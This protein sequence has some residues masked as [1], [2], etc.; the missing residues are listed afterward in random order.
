MPPYQKIKLRRDRDAKTCPTCGFPIRVV[1]RGGGSADHY[2]FLTDFDMDDALAHEDPEIAEQHKK[3]REGKRTLA[4]VGR[5]PASCALAPWE[6]ESVEIWS[7]NETHASPWFM[8]WNR[9]FQMHP[10]EILTREEDQRGIRGHY[11]WLQQ[12]H[13]NGIYMLHQYLEFPN[14]VEYPLNRV[15]ERFFRGKIWKGDQ[16]AQQ[17]GSTFDYMMALALLEDRFDRIEIYGFDMAAES[18]KL[19]GYVYQKPGALFWLGV[20]NGLDIEIY[21]PPDNQL[22]SAPLYGYQWYPK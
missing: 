20:A 4:M 12:D 18:M 6:D 11:E 7:L 22:F 3:D 17:L 14:S 2:E 8:R 16:E 9:W 19:A 5:S 15:R 13:G 21:T 1:R 10:W